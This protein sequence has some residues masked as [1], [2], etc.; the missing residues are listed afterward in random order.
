MTLRLRALPGKDLPE[1]FEGDRIVGRYR[2]S[3]GVRKGK[4]RRRKGDASEQD[5]VSSDDDEDDEDDDGELDGEY[6]S[7]DDDSMDED[8]H[9]KKRRQGFRIKIFKVLSIHWGLMPYINLVLEG[10]IFSI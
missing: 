5:E 2:K 4:G 3:K 10:S 7:L 1:L 8:G 6:K 9:R